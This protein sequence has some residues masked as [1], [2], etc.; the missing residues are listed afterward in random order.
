MSANIVRETYFLLHAIL[1]GA[2]ITFIYDW[3]R[4]IRRVIRHNLFFLSL[5]DLIFWIICSIQIF[6]MLYEENNG[7]IRWFAIIG[8]MLGMFLYKL[9]FGRFFVTYTARFLR[10]IFRLMGRALKFLGRP[11]KKLYQR[12]R[13]WRGKA[14]HGITIFRKIIR[15]RLTS[16]VKMVKILLCKQ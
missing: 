14:S 12:S 9:L 5:E 15:N 16:F 3:L 11:L 6:L 1:L 4:V 13:Y 7:A 2:F 10:T 8:A